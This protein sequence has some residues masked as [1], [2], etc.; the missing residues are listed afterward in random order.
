M[1]VCV[2]CCVCVCVVCVC[3]SKVWNVIFIVYFLKLK[4]IHL[5]NFR[6]A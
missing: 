6:G 2:V 5:N 4:I 1:C 3:V